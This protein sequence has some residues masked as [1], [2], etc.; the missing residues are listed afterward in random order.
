VICNKGGNPLEK[1]SFATI[2]TSKCPDWGE[3]SKNFSTF[4]ARWFKLQLIEVPLSFK[5]DDDIV[6]RRSGSTSA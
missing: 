4:R 1:E 6:D 2:V 3:I 5:V